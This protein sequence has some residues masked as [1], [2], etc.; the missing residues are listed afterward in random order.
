MSVTLGLICLI[1]VACSAFLASSEAALFS[2][3]RYQIR[4]LRDRVPKAHRSIK[5]LTADPSG[6]LLVLLFSNEVLNVAISTIITGS[7][8]KTAE[9]W[10]HINE[11]FGLPEWTNQV[12]L[13]SLLT[14]PIILILCE[15]TPKA[16]GARANQ[17]LAI[18]FSGPIAELYDLLKPVRIFS[19][20]LIKGFSPTAPVPP[21]KPQT[22]ASIE[23]SREVEALN[24]E[25]ERQLQEDDFLVM[26]EEGHREGTINESELDLIRNVFDLDDTPVAEIQTPFSQVTTVLESLPVRDA[27]RLTQTWRFSR[28]PVLSRDRKRV[29][30]VLYRKD[31]LLSRLSQDPS[32]LTVSD[33][34]RRPL[35]LS[36][37]TKLNAVFRKLKLHQTHIAIIET[38][39]HTPTGIVTMSDVL[40]ELFDELYEEYPT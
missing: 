17:T 12:L 16:I 31:L 10:P 13:G 11:T 8:F 24:D 14:A 23:T 39:D 26:V 2:L 27:L 32:A 33:V 1:L 38:G 19:Q 34:M 30:G 40:G 28:I 7:V 29:V 4:S 25:A 6:L 3:S 35:T 9:S 18:L 15:I 5:R 37:T 20:V 36:P 22:A 21:K